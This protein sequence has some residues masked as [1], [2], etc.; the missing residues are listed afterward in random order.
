LSYPILEGII[1]PGKG[2]S[3]CNHKSD[4]FNQL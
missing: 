3:Y 2:F 1:H 4:M